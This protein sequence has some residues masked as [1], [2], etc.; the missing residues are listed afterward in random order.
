MTSVVNL[1]RHHRNNHMQLRICYDDLG[2]EG[3]RLDKA[4]ETFL[5]ALKLTGSIRLFIFPVTCSLLLICI[6]ITLNLLI[7]ILKYLLPTRSTQH[8]LVF[9]YQSQVEELNRTKYC[10]VV[11]RVLEGKKKGLRK[12]MDDRLYLRPTLLIIH[13]IF[14]VASGKL[15][16]LSD[17]IS[18]IYAKRSLGNIVHL[19]LKFPIVTTHCKFG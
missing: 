16:I 14:C 12:E 10:T 5:R 9:K 3:E 7:Y 19:G 8:W 1:H 18:D 13:I 4:I 17:S 6:G 11:P 2:R 15:L